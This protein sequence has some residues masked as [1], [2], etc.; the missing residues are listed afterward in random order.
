MNFAKIDEIIKTGKRLDSKEAYRLMK[1]A[2]EAKKPLCMLWKIPNYIYKDWYEKMKANNERVGVKIPTTLEDETTYF[3]HSGAKAFDGNMGGYSIF[4][5]SLGTK[6]R[7]AHYECERI[8][9]YP[10]EWAIIID[11]KEVEDNA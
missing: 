1:E 5:V 9:R 11:P 3:V 4:A 7:E 2:T 6:K 10:C 8:E